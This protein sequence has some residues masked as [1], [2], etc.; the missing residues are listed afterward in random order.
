[1]TFVG[2]GG[3][4]GGCVDTGDE[5]VSVCGCEAGSVGENKDDGYGHGIN[6]CNGEDAGDGCC[7]GCC[8][9]GGNCCCGGV[10]KAELLIFRWILMLSVRWTNKHKNYCDSRVT[11]VTENQIFGIKILNESIFLIL[12]FGPK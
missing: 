12:A 8:D 11:F 10:G 5:D 1:M 2:E 4:D 9:G 6:V 3:A 7:E